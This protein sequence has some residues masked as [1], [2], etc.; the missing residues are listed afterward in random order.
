MLHF[1]LPINPNQNP[2]VSK[3]RVNHDDGESDYCNDMPIIEDYFN[4]YAILCL[5]H[6]I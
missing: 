1:D 2:D 5:N 3:N 4:H 6:F